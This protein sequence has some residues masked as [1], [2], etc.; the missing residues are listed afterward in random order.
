MARGTEVNHLLHGQSKDDRPFNLVKVCHPC[1][2]H[3]VFGFHGSA[4][5]WD[6]ERSFRLKLAQGF[7]LPREAWRYL[8]GV[9][10][11]PGVEPDTEE[12]FRLVERI[13]MAERAR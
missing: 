10:A 4:P 6:R 3:P 12:A 8:D 9:D 11:W 2:Q 13:A 5:R 1:H 7:V